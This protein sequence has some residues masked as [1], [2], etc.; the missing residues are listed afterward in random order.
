VKVDDEV[1][2]L[3]DQINATLTRAT[4]SG[5]LAAV[6]TSGDLPAARRLSSLLDRVDPDDVDIS[7]VANALHLLGS[8]R[9]YRCQLVPDGAEDRAAAL[10]LLRVP[11]SLALDDIPAPLRPE[12]A[13]AALP[14]A[15]ATLQRAIRMRTRDQFDGAITF[16]QRVADDLAG[17]H[18]D[19]AAFVACLG[20]VFQLRFLDGRSREDLDRSIDFLGEAVAGAVDPA[21]REDTRLFLVQSLQTRLTETAEPADLERMIDLCAAGVS[22][23]TDDEARVGWL[24]FWGDALLQRYERDGADADRDQ[25]IEA[26]RSALAIGPTVDLSQTA[27][28]Y[29]LAWALS[30]GYQPG[31]SGADLT[32][33]LDLAETAVRE[34]A[35]D[36]AFREPAQRLLDTVRE[37]HRR[38][39]GR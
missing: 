27:L 11:Y 26:K 12:L 6:L 30:R 25:A 15:M 19:R 4:E 3:M 32:E 7:V 2:S 14:L 36:D 31:K 13:G 24:T 33:A 23:A 5:E 17:D 10:A 28:R 39:G 38:F 16:G 8:L 34:A 9:W 18:A 20:T 21:T 35:P 37:V 29:G 22:A 1:L